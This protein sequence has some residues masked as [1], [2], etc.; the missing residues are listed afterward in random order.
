MG[1]EWCNCLKQ[2]ISNKFWSDVFQS[3]AYVGKELKINSNSD[4]MQ[5]CLWYNK[6]ISENQ[7]FLPLWFK[8]GIYTVGDITDSSGKVLGL[9]EINAK[10]NLKVN[11]LHYFRLRTEIQNFVQKNKKDNFFP[12]QNPVF[13][14][15]LHLIMHQKKGCKDIYLII[16]ETDKKE[17]TNCELKWS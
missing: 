14:P 2:K 7:M 4:I 5:S 3:W 15:H 16:N 12:H 1:P 17:Q 9:V 6:H 11:F 13:P 8:K 10:F